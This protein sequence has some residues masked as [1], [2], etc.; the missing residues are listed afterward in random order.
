MSTPRRPDSQ[1]RD[2]QVG[3][4]AVDRMVVHQF[5]PARSSPGG[6]DTCLRGI[7]RYSPE[8]LQLAI[9]GVDTGAGDVTRRLGVWERH[10]FS[11]RT[12]W[13]LPVARLDPADQSRRIPHS[14]RLVAGLLRY[15]TRLPERR[16]VE[17]HRMDVALALYLLLRTPLGYFIHTQDSGITGGR[18]DSLWRWFG[19]LHPRFEKFVVSRARTVTVFNEN[20]AAVV[21]RWNPRT[22]FSPTWFDPGLLATGS[23][24]R[25]MD[26]I[27]WV[28]RLEILKDPALALD[29]FE[30]LAARHP[31]RNWS[32]EILGS[33]TRL[34]NLRDRVSRMPTAL[35]ARVQVRGRVEPAEVAATMARG[36]VFLMTSHPGYEGYPCVLVEAMASGMVPIVTQGSDTG[37]LVRHGHT[38]YVTSRDPSEIAD[39][40][41]SSAAIDR[42]V[43]RDAVAS[44]D[45]PTVVGQMYA[46]RTSDD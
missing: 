13:F 45:A 27:V 46:G 37:A 18:S 10:R 2:K 16:M 34:T 8:G 1:K 12:V 44:L 22:R 40:I 35:R 28:G 5:D 23:P 20:K 14:I 38:G 25:D 30:N 42:V 15:R 7:F 6:I 24:H 33:G 3:P 29:V 11:E 31:E 21:R 43:V 36:G 39:R 17:A 4:R 9:V 32:L 41:V 19:G 26:K